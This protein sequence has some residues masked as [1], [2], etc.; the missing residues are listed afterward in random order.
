MKVIPREKHIYSFRPDADTVETIESG[1][2]VIF[3]TY[4]SYRDQLKSESIDKNFKLEGV[5]PAT[6]PVYVNGAEPGDTLKISVLSLEL[7]E[8]GSMYLRPGVGVLKKYVDRPEVKKLKIK[9]KKVIY[10]DK[11][12]FDLKPMIGVIG[13]ALDEEISTFSPGKHGGNMDTK[14]IT[15]GAVI[16]LPV[17][18]LGA[19][20]AI[21]DLHA[22]MGD[23]EVPICGVEIGGRVH[24]K[25]EVIKTK[26]S[27]WPV[28]EDKDNYYAIAS[29]KTMDE[30]CE[31]ATESMFLL[32][33]K[34]NP[35]LASNDIIRLIGIQG[36]L[37]I[38]QVVNPLKTAK[39]VLPKKLI[40]CGLEEVR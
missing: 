10:N 12:S 34:Q 5:N 28:L 11:Y 23:G 8:E 20:L 38:S 31:L 29:A 25:V 3:H 24:I 22:I 13:V 19:K 33:R 32:L 36:D 17:F 7:E 18:T 16:Y 9:N 35:K 37:K 39:F 6:G 21:G 14:E 40:P 15:A 1:E 2:E 26:L 4:D 27:D 30:A